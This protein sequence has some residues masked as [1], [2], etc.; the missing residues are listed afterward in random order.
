MYKLINKLDR[1]NYS[2]AGIFTGMILGMLMLALGIYTLIANLPK[3]ELFLTIS[4]LITLGIGAL[5][6]G[7]E[8]YRLRK[9]RA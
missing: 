2:K 7:M 3:K 6:I 4:S 1:F 8:L 9:M 5:C